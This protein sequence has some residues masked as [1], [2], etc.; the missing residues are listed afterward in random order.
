M[1]Q[2]E[3]VAPD[4]AALSE[5]IDLSKAADRFA[6]ISVP[7]RAENIDDIERV[8][9]LQIYAAAVSAGAP[10]PDWRADDGIREIRSRTRSKP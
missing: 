8:G 5:R 1:K 7:E 4:P 2:S 6:Q 3:E 9:W 10:R